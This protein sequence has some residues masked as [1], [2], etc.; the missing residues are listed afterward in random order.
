MT[1]LIKWITE[2]QLWDMEKKDE[3]NREYNKPLQVS[4]DE[5]KSDVLK[6][7]YW[8]KTDNKEEQK[9]NN[10]S[11]EVITDKMKI[12]ENPNSPLIDW[13]VENWLLSVE[14]GE[15]IKA[16]L[17]KWW[18]LKENLWNLDWID[19]TKTKQVVESIKYL[20]K[21]EAKK[22][23]LDKFNK[24]FLDKIDWL[25]QVV[26]WSKN[27]EKE[28]VWRNKDLIKLIGWNYLPLENIDWINE[29]N[30]VAMD[31]AI[32]TSLNQL[33]DGKSFKRPDTFNDMLN[34][35]KNSDLSFEERFT[36]L[37]KIDILI[38]N[39]QS[40]SNWKQAKAFW[41]MKKWVEKNVQTL[42]EQFNN[43][44]EL[45]EVA[46]LKDNNK[47]LQNLIEEAKMLKDESE[48]QWEVFVSWEIDVLLNWLNEWKEQA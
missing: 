44:K 9:I 1:P 25:K 31:R 8:V 33:M 5:Q 37:K 6:N 35:V 23:C 10:E 28:L 30:N 3:A 17:I 19:K 2:P 38:D 13:F 36:E 29:N 11:N 34:V 20:T 43:L 39:D 47:E 21:P 7:L 15:I 41:V 14:E 40:R 32:K 46:K 16:T 4:L 22:E 24:D 18:D 27:W 48:A 45:I 12:D 42:E 26:D